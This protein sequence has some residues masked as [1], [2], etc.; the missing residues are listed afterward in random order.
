MS[1]WK[2][3]HDIWSVSNFL[4]LVGFCFVFAYHPSIQ[5]FQ[6]YRNW[7]TASCVL[8][9]YQYFCGSKWCLAHGYMATPSENRTLRPLATESDALPL[10]H[11]APHVDKG[12][13]NCQTW[14]IRIEYELLRILMKMIFETTLKFTEIIIIRGIKK[15]IFRNHWSKC[16]DGMPN[17]PPVIILFYLNNCRGAFLRKANINVML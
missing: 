9:Y 6:S 11:R 10:G 4:V 2:Y 12:F 7:T 8:P 5:I 1:A 15:F 17:F 3:M 16:D 14:S 13:F